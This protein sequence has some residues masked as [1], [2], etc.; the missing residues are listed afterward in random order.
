MNKKKQINWD[1][2]EIKPDLCPHCG[3]DFNGK[4]IIF[5]IKH[6]QNEHK[7]ILGIQWPPTP[8]KRFEINKVFLDSF[9]KK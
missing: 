3:I 9:N 7:A 6:M 2:P 5:K 4:G 8:E 1:T